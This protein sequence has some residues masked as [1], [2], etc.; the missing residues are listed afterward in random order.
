MTTATIIPKL[1]KQLGG[2]ES[3]LECLTALD[4][5]QQQTLELQLQKARAIQHEHVRNAAVDAINHLPRLLRKPLL[6]MFEV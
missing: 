2:D 6:K 3:Q 5:A 4:E 1:A